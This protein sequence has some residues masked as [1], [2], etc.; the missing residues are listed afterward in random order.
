MLFSI[1]IHLCV[2][3]RC[4][5][6]EQ[7]AQQLSIRNLFLLLRHL[8]FPPMFLWGRVVRIL[9]AFVTYA[10]YGR[11]RVL[12]V[13]RGMRFGR[14]CTCEMLVAQW[15]ISHARL[16]Q[17]DTLEHGNRTIGLK[18]TALLPASQNARDPMEQPHSKKLLD[19]VR[20]ALRP[21]HYSYC[22]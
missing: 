13:K 21:K 22:A 15:G 3:T 10:Q 1:C 7:A 4:F 2:L 11:K 20:D 12:I 5:R 18:Y 17:V 19:Q 16:L 14:R 8:P 9:S 6:R